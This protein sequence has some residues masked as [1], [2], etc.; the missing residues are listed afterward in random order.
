MAFMDLAAGLGVAPLPLHP[1]RLDDL[2]KHLVLLEVSRRGQ[3]T[4]SAV[5]AITATLHGAINH[6]IVSIGSFF[7][8]VEGIRFLHDCSVHQFWVLEGLALL[9]IHAL[10]R[11]ASGRLSCRLHRLAR[12]ASTAVISMSLRG[13]AAGRN[14]SD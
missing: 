12:V 1:R 6:A 10:Y 4:C 2:F 13:L 11:I 14:C 7:D 8:D 9:N 5:T 3:G